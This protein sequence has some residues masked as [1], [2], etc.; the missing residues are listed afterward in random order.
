[1]VGGVFFPFLILFPTVLYSLFPFSVYH[2]RSVIFFPGV[3][4]GWIHHHDI[5]LS[6]PLFF[7]F[8]L[9]FSGRPSLCYHLSPSPPLKPEKKKNLHNK[10]VKNLS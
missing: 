3:I 10:I 5:Y 1:M 4:R 2:Y 9:S 6:P 7:S 8:P